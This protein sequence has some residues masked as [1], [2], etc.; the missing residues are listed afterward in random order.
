MAA[1][2]MNTEQA[3]FNMIEQQ[4]RPWNVLDPEVLKLLSVV[5]REDFVPADKRDLAFADL[6]IPL[7][8]VPG[9]TMLAPKIEARM[10][11]ELGL[12]ATDTVL[13]IGT[14]SGYMAAL[15]AAKAEF[16]YTVEID[17]ALVELARQNLQQAGVANVCV[18]IGDGAQ[19]WPLY[20]PYDAIVVSAS[21]PVLP[22]ALRRQLK[23]GGRLV[24]IVGEAPVM[25]VLLVTR[26]DEDAFNTDVVFETVAAPLVNATPRDKF[27][28]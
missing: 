23:I 12:K 8:A 14:G 16:V 10:L 6:E 2:A 11:Q 9:Q 15:L 17:P 5:K 4:I 13:E 7:G 21:T 25:Q 20:A 1:A 26:T 19:G 22:D 27:V 24:A 18:D 3:R 28:F